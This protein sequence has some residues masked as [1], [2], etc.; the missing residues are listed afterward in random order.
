MF[1]EA[2]LVGV[3]GWCLMVFGA[4]P[5][6]TPIHI[7]VLKKFMI[8]LIS[9]SLCGIFAILNGI[10]KTKFIVRHFVEIKNY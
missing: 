1:V 4:L 10:L 2:S 6:L 7:K 9:D 5:S 3:C 8:N